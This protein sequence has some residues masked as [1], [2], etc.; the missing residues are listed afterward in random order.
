V[1][2]PLTECLDGAHRYP[3]RVAAISPLLVLGDLR[4]QE[5]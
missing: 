4:N 5:A 1:P 3:T 2:E